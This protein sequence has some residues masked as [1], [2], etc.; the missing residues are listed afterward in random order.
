MD[1]AVQILRDNREFYQACAPAYDAGRQFS[2][3]REQARV[4]ADLE[5]IG[6]S[7][8]LAGAAVMDIGCG[9]GYYA[10]MAVSL[11]VAKVHLLDLNQVFLESAREKVLNTRPGTHVHCHLADLGSFIRE[12]ADLLRDI[13]IYL[14]GGV[15]QYVPDHEAVLGKL[16]ADLG[17]GCFYI[18]S[19]LV[20][21][22]GR[23]RRI[24]D[25]LARIDYFVHRVLHPGSRGQRHLPPN[26]VTLPVDP[27]R[28]QQLYADRGYELRFYT[29]SSFHNL[30]FDH[31]H[32]ALRR[33]FPSMGSRFTLIALKRGEGRR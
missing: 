12:R 28:L 19:T 32:R 16:A 20:P 6:S 8:P 9:T 10:M 26:K 24:E 29:Y 5:W 13:D 15:V 31:L 18:T 1:E 7:S 4:R 3:L 25:L 22:G 30:V 17:Q 33:L 27:Q 11:G 21:G 23:Y 14:M 2:Y